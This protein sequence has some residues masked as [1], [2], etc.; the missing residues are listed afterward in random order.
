LLKIE[1]L[2]KRYGK[3][4]ALDQVSMELEDK[5]A[6]LLLGPNGAGK[7]TLIRCVMG[8]VYF[9]G[10]IAVDGQDVVHNN[11]AAKS[12]VGYVPQESSFYDNMEV[13]DQSYLI[14]ELK[15][16]SREEVK[17]RL[18]QVDLWDAR[19]KRVGSLSSGMKQ[20][21]GIAL[22]LLGDPPLMIFD[23]P[24]SNI[25]LRGQL[26]FENLLTDLSSQGKTLLIATHLSG[27]DEH[28]QQAVV[29]D[30]GK[31]MASGQPGEL[32]KR[33]NAIDTIY[34]RVSEDSMATAKGIAEGYSNGVM[35]RGGWLLIPVQVSAKASLAKAILNGC[36][37][38]DILI[39]PATIESQYLKLIGGVS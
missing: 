35:T 22:A 39:Q 32:L 29:L 21:L 8:L 6:T 38:L 24:T 18:G 10:K 3:F 5:S 17:D 20:R 12:M 14:A 15:G 25:D 11:K 34:V 26:E 16:R 30:K 36:N 37:V 1:N 33:I 19:N 4:T 9:Q 31:V 7:T 28:A 13:L 27:L 23:E 2:T